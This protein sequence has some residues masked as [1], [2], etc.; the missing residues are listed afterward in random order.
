METRRG[1]FIE[2][3]MKRRRHDRTRRRDLFSEARGWKLGVDTVRSRSP[4]D[5]FDNVRLG[6]L[7][8]IC[9]IN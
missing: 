5:I 8:E 1:N 3:H 4:K 7:F 6:W 2:M 9:G